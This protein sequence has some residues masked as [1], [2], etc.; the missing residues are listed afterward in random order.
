MAGGRGAVNNAAA[1]GNDPRRR[2]PHANHELLR[3]GPDPRD[4][5]RRDLRAAGDVHDGVPVPPLAVL[6][7]HRHPEPDRPVQRV[8]RGQ[9]RSLDIVGGADGA[10]GVSD[11]RLAGV[12]QPGDAAVAFEY[13]NAELLL[14]LENLPAQRRLAD[15]AGGGGLAEL[16]EIGDRDEVVKIAQ[17]HRSSA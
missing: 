8:A 3:P 12:R 6:G 5:G 16:T 2:G 7:D 13:L 14:E 9:G 4:R 15:V 10:S 1:P 11:D 17:V